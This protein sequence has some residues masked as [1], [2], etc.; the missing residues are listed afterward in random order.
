[1]TPL[2]NDKNMHKPQEVREEKK[3]LFPPLH[4]DHSMRKLKQ[5][6]RGSPQE[7]IEATSRQPGPPFQPRAETA[8]EM[9]AGNPS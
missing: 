3:L 1:M 2:H 5:R 9:R 4:S 8:L 6:R 7:G